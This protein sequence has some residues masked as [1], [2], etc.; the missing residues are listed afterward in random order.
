VPEY[1]LDERP[2]TEAEIRAG[3][4]RVIRDTAAFLIQER[5][6]NE[7]ELNGKKNRQSVSSEVGRLPFDE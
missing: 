1:Y 3:I 2:P 5:K 6:E 7:V 4:E